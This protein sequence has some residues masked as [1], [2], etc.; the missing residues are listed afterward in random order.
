MQGSKVNRDNNS[1]LQPCSIAL[2]CYISMHNET[3]SDVGWLSNDVIDLNRILREL[4]L[5]P[6][7]PFIPRIH[8]LISRPAVISHEDQTSMVGDLLDAVAL[9]NLKP[10]HSSISRKV[11]VDLVC[12]V[13]Q[14]FADIASTDNEAECIFRT[15]E[16]PIVI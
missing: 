14:I 3:L 2:N 8:K 11:S 12:L 6:C 1:L 13:V 10:G 5:L 7:E 9:A 16:R 15:V 4:E